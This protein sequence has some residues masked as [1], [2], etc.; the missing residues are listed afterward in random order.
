MLAHVDHGKSALSD[1]LISANGIISSRMAGK[2]RYMDSREDEQ[3]R[4]I[5]MKSSS[6]SLGHRSSENSPLNIINLIDSP[7]HVDFSGEV[8]AALCICDGAFIVVDVVEGVCVQTVT[9][10]RAALAH[11]LRPV[12]V[13]NKIDRLFAELNLD[14]MEAYDHIVNILGQVNVI[15][16]VRQVEQMMAA[17]SV[18]KAPEGIDSEWKL[19]DKLAD[20]GDAAV[21]GYFSPELGNVVFS[22]A[23][24]GWAFRLINFARIFSAKFGINENVLNKTLWGDYYLQSKTKRIIRRKPTEVRSK[25]KPM[26]VQFILSNIHS[27]YDTLLSTQH[28]LELAIQKRT[29]FVSKLGLKVSARDIKHRDAATALRSIMSAWLPAASCLLDSVIEKMPSAAEAQSQNDRLSSLWPNTDRVPDL[30]KISNMPV[31]ELARSY[32]EQYDAIAGTVSDRTAPV[33]A[34]VA[35]MVEGA[36][37]TAGSEMNIRM[38]KRPEELQAGKETASKEGPLPNEYGSDS[39][40]MIAMT[41]VMSGTIAVGDSVFVYSPK[42]IVSKDGTFDKNTVSKSTVTG[43]FLLMGR[44]MSPLK[45][46]CAG[47]V[48]G[49]AG[50]EDV[51][52]KTATISTKPP[53]H[54][55]PAGTSSSSIL[56]LDKEAVVRVAV[57][58]DHPGDVG[59][60]Q[61]G[62][63]RLNQADPAVETLITAKGEHVIAA[64]GE[65]HLERCLKDLRERFAKNVRIHVS[66]PIVSFRE[67]VCGGISSNAPM[68]VSDLK[69]GVPEQGPRDTREKSNENYINSGSLGIDTNIPIDEKA[70]FEYGRDGL[71]SSWRVNI[72]TE[73]EPNEYVSPAFVKY[74]RFIRVGN[75]KTSF[76]LTA[77]PLPSPLATALEKVAAALR[78]GELGQNENEDGVSESKEE[79]HKALEKFSKESAT[80]KY[81]SSMI[82]T[83]WKKR[84]FPRVWSC[85]P[86][87]FG[88]NILVGPW[89]CLGRSPLLQELFEGS[90]ELVTTS[91][92]IG[93]EMEKGIISGFQL[94]TRAGPLCEEPMQGVC[95]FVDMVKVPDEDYTGQEGS[96]E[97]LLHGMQGL[98]KK[99]EAESS[100]I[101][102]LII[103]SMRE[104]VRLSVMNGNARLMEG[105]LHVDISVPKDV[106]GKAY[107]VLGQ[108]RGR[109]IKEYMKEGVNVFGIEAYLPVEDSFGFTDILR[110]QTSGFGVPQMVFSHWEIVEIDPFWFPQTEE[111]IEDLGVSD[112]T[113]ETN[114][115]ARKLINKVRRRK[116]LR[117]EEKIVEKAE[118][119]RTLSRKK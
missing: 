74:G 56:G 89:A 101:S 60:L 112:T 7:G 98:D 92:R 21:S 66:K 15:M 116:G 29:T 49:I 109:V 12:L 20:N 48:V 119:Q 1:S 53:G 8:E 114:N 75:E 10:L 113:A 54:C 71:G 23:I 22:S 102:G 104:C 6:I 88:S 91:S 2:V 76:R 111:E 17:A 68:P 65:L 63:R 16:G 90:P 50:L 64:N 59:I 80:R 105:M 14:P 9:V 51:V 106:L 85:G 103:G 3:S 61:A 96:I 4:G 33:V 100:N 27:I 25:A 18:D 43:L 5:T 19:E 37:E 115:L 35:K 44:A 87:S 95:I 57:E 107:T 117:V 81:S 83:Y 73:S 34:Y 118:K 13:L 47:S 78:E 62:L 40:Q 26:F 108:R 79:I 11:A 82:Y 58:P 31:S 99:R 42:Y 67:T 41:R 70:D 72:E 30:D 84:I 24:D 110:K 55:L 77:A 45:S 38:P 97:P 69:P 36:R 93:R 86:K 94:G 32:R 52:V 46:V 28:D 39:V